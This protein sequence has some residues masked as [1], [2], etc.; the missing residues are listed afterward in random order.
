MLGGLKVDDDQ[1]ASLARRGAVVLFGEGGHG[2]CR[3][4]LQ[5]GSDDNA[6][7]GEDG[8]GVGKD[9]IRVRQLRLPIQHKVNQFATTR[10]PTWS[11][12]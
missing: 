5:G 12:N 4:D 2:S 1:L 11:S 8:V 7:L 6:Q 3:H 9:E 10:A